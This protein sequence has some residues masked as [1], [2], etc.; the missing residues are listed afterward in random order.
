M[1][2]PLSIRSA[3]IGGML[4]LA[5]V[6]TVIIGAV[7]AISINRSVVHEAQERVNHDLDT[8]SA[9]YQQSARMLANQIQGRTDAFQAAGG[10]ETTARLLQVK[11]EVRISILNMCDSSGRPLA[12]G[13][14][15]RNVHV[16]IDADPVLRQALKGKV[17]WGTMLLDESRLR[18]EGYTFVGESLAV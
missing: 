9:L 3:L 11:R 1:R 14:P 17:A 13:Y 4:A 6:V 12:G 8:I 10:P 15:D 7:G 2:R 5:A 16:P 18:M